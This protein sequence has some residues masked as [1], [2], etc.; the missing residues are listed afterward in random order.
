LPDFVNANPEVRAVTKLHFCRIGF[1]A[2]EV[3]HNRGYRNDRYREKFSSNQLLQKSALAGF[4]ASK[5][6]DAELC[7]L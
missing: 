3:G 6:A 5:D 2:G 1:A 4:E 7:A